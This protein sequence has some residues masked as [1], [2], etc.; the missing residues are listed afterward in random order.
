MVN[1]TKIFYTVLIIIILLVVHL[2]N[3]KSINPQDVDKI[4]VVYASQGIMYNSDEE[5][6]FLFGIVKL[7]KPDNS[8]GYSIFLDIDGY[9][10]LDYSG[11]YSYY[12]TYKRE[13]DEGYIQLTPDYEKIYGSNPNVECEM[14]ADGFPFFKGG[15][16]KFRQIKGFVIDEYNP[17]LTADVEIYFEFTRDGKLDIEKSSI[18]VPNQENKLKDSP[19]VECRRSRSVS[20]PDGP[21]EVQDSPM[22]CTSKCYGLLSE[23]GGVPIKNPYCKD[24]TIKILKEFPFSTLDLIKTG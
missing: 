22:S 16:W 14:D 17:Y 21:V 11:S 18:L 15:I 2:V 24:Y 3:P 12:C 20:T 13:G 1:K 7:I 10:M 9:M 8:S 23:L 6:N 5:K 19:S 4:E